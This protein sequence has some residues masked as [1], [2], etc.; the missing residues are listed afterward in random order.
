MTADSSRA[1]R[2][3]RQGPFKASLW[4]SLDVR[5]EVMP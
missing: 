4:G 3:G 1:T 2:V 5:T